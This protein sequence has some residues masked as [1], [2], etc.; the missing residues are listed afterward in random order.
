MLSFDS[1]YEKVNTSVNDKSRLSEAFEYGKAM[2]EGQFR[3][4][5]GDPYFIHPIR[6]AVSL[7]NFGEEMI[8]AGL[9]HDV[10]EDTDT[11]LFDIES[12]FGA[13]VAQY[14]D[15]V[16]KRGHE[17]WVV[18]LERIAF[19]YSEVIYIKIAD[20][21]DNLSDGFKTMK[22]KTRL[23]YKD[24]VEIFNRLISQFNLQGL[25]VRK[26]KDIHSKTF[27]GL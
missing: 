2:H 23:K 1:F 24:H 9:L 12:K 20:R 25:L 3:K 6:V 8:I 18:T 5:S 21:I 4:N 16:T 11:T 17:S 10:V 22:E 19:T 14:V 7:V 27:N 26:L 13:K 15:G